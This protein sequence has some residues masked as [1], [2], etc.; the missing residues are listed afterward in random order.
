MKLVEELIQ[1][2]T[3]LKTLICSETTPNIS[4]ILPLKEMILKSMS[5]G[6]QDSATVKAAITNDLAKRYTDPNLH[7]YLQMA[8]A[9]DPRFKS[10]PYLDEDSRDKLY[11]NIINEIL[12]HEQQ[13]LFDYYYI[14]FCLFFLSC[15]VLIVLCI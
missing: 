15:V 8:T 1:V 7:E 2:L 5:P 12:E 9:L 10:L 4:M 13:V 11:R 6:D 3:P 14:F